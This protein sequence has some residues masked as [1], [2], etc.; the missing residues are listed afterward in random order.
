MAENK[1][2][3]VDIM[4]SIKKVVANRNPNAISIISRGNKWA[5]YKIGNKKATALFQHREQ[6]YFKAKQM[7][8]CIIVHNK[9]G[10]V[11][12]KEGLV[13]Y[14]GWYLVSE[15][16]PEPNREIELYDDETGKIRKVKTYLKNDM[17]FVELKKEKN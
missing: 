3:S 7:S 8:N 15:K 1:V 6:A 2:N 10:G 4:S 16:L 13:N 9:N 5:V 17:I 12:F 11:D 14:I